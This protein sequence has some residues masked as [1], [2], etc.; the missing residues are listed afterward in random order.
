MVVGSVCVWL[1]GVCGCHKCV[2]GCGCYMCMGGCA[3]SIRVQIHHAFDIF[4]DKTLHTH[5]R[6]HLHSY[7]RTCAVSSKRS[8]RELRLLRHMNHE[9]VSVWVWLLGVCGCGCYKCVGG[10]SCHMCMGVVHT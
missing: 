3:W 8:Y 10:C 2:V 1:L 4:T 6:R 5:V 9:N 7:I